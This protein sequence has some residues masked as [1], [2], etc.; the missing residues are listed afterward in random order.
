MENNIWKQE[1]LGDTKANEQNENTPV[2]AW[3]LLVSWIFVELHKSW[4]SPS[5]VS[6]HTTNK[7]GISHERL[8]PLT[9]RLQLSCVLHWER[10]HTWL[11][12]CLSDWCISMSG[13]YLGGA[14]RLSGT[15]LPEPTGPPAL[16]S[17]GWQD[18]QQFVVS[19]CTLETR[20]L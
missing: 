16:S 4:K 11:M 3:W 2:S 13:G 15:V 7:S 5:K 12:L 10:H 6:L 17:R 14:E 8:R 20:E 9:N 1:T 19:G 18:L